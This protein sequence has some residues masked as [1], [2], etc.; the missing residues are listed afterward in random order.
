ML[1]VREVPGRPLRER[2]VGWHRVLPVPSCINRHRNLLSA[3]RYAHLQAVVSKARGQR[4]L[5][6]H[7]KHT[8]RDGFL[9]HRA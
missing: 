7:L 3:E 1:G 9:G 8:K 5:Q 2:G 4:A 6:L